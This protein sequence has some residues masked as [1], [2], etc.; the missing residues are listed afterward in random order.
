MQVWNRRHILAAAGGAAAATF[1]PPAFAQASNAPVRIGLLTIKTGPLASPG[2]QFE[3]G[4]TV[5][6]DSRKRMIAGRKIELI[7][8]DTAAQ[9]AQALIKA[10]EL[11]ERDKVD[12]VVGPLAAFEAIAIGD[13]IRSAAVPTIIAAAAED[14]TQRKS[15]PWI[16]RSSGSPAQFSYPLADYAANTLKLKRVVTIADDLAYG[17][18]ALGGFMRVFEESGGKVVQRLWAPFN[19]TD[20]GSYISQIRPD[21]DAVVA[22]FAGQNA[23]RFI[24]QFAEFGMK[25]KMRLLSTLTMTDESLLRT[26]NEEAVGIIS[27]GPYTATVNTP[28][29]KAM[30]EAMVKATGNV[31]G[32][33]VSVG[34]TAGLV[35]EHALRDLKGKFE[36]RNDLMRALRAVRMDDD[37]RGKVS[38]DNWGNVVSD[39]QVFRVARGPDGKLRNEII[40][41][42][43]AVSQF[44]TY[45]PKEFLANPVYSRDYPPAR[46]LG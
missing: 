24:R 20:Y 34:Y 15:S 4:L 27:S 8:A 25:E 21:V 10:R 7:V 31:P 14:L 12:V 46:H 6:L 5:L 43:P 13:Y 17:H 1:N 3:D 19:A 18:E 28:A 42:Y 30:V 37:P 40:K 32:Y 9:P 35:I 44:W 2:K 38:F 11:V 26:M 29:N 23:V 33:Y 36:T 45:P 22:G 41:T 39:Q 16:M